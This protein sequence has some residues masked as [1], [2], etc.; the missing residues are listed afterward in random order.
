MSTTQE[1]KPSLTQNLVLVPW[2]Q[3]FEPTWAICTAA[4]TS[5]DDF[6]HLVAEVFATAGTTYEEKDVSAK[7][8]AEVILHLLR[9]RKL[10]QDMLDRGGQTVEVPRG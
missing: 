1:G 10:V 7:E 2:S 6:G 5:A 8:N 4:A 9:D 3:H